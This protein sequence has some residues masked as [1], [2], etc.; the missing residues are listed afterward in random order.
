M[1]PRCV[2]EVPR[3]TRHSKQQAKINIVGGMFICFCV[4]NLVDFLL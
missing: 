1:A 4:L 3:Q 2:N